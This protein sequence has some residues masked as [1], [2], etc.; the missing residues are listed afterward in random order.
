MRIFLSS[1][2]SSFSVP[3]SINLAAASLAACRARSSTAPPAAS[4]AL[5][6]AETVSASSSACHSAIWAWFL[7]L[8]MSSRFWKSASLPRISRLASSPIPFAT[9]LPLGLTPPSISAIYCP[10]VA[11]RFLP[12]SVSAV[13]TSSCSSL[14]S[15]APEL[16]LTSASAIA[17]RNQLARASDSFSFNSPC[18]PIAPRIFPVTASTEIPTSPYF[19]RSS[20]ASRA[21]SAT[22]SLDS[23][24]ERDIFSSVCKRSSA[25]RSCRCASSPL[26]S[27]SAPSVENFGVLDASALYAVI[28]ATAAPIATAKAVHGLAIAA[29]FSALRA[30]E[31]VAIEPA[32]AV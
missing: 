7:R 30:F 12:K 28:A 14:L 2:L 25:A 3:S 24:C 4:A 16:S 10:H 15:I 6:A 32:S 22:S 9:T 13:P 11:L 29:T 20:S 21:P 18:A 8:A 17:P 1:A 27:A 5:V 23:L 19:C 26:A 31:T